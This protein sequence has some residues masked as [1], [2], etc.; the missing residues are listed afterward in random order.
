M[1]ISGIDRLKSQ[2]TE[3]AFE[4]LVDLLDD[5][6]YAVEATVIVGNG[7]LVWLGMEIGVTVAVVFQETIFCLLMGVMLFA[8]DVIRGYRGLCVEEENLNHI[9]I[10]CN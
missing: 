8:V 1:T 3:L 9:G 6:V 2:F 7:S 5:L 4:L 10:T